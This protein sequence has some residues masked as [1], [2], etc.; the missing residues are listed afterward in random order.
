[1]LN[2]FRVRYA[3][4][5]IYTDVGRILVAINPFKSLSISGHEWI[6]DYRNGTK[7][8]PHIFKIA[9]S[10]MKGFA[11]NDKPQAV[12]V[13]GE[14]GAGKTESAK[15]VFKYL[16]D[17][18]G[19]NADATLNERILQSNPI[20]EAFGNAKTVHNNNSSRFGKFVQCKMTPGADI[21]GAEIF[22]YLLE[23]NRVCHSNKG[24]RNYHIFYQ[25]ARSPKGAEYYM[26]DKMWYLNQGDN[27]CPG[28]DDAQEFLDLCRAFSAMGITS[29]EQDMIFSIV[30]GVAHLGNVELVGVNDGEE[31]E[32]KNMKPVE[33]AAEF[34]GGC[35]AETLAATFTKKELRVGRD[36]T[37]KN[38]KPA[39]SLAAR[40]G[41]AMFMYDKLF[42]WLVQRLNS[43]LKETEEGKTINSSPN[44]IGV[45]DIAGF[46]NFP[47]N[48]L[49]QLFINLANENLQ[50][51]FNFQVFQ[52]HLADYAREG[53]T[54]S[55]FHYE[56][57]QIIMDLI[58]ND[59]NSILKTLDDVMKR[60]KATD[61]LFVNELDKVHKSHKHYI[62]AK[63]GGTPTFGIDHYAGD[64]TYDA[65]GWCEKNNV[66]TLPGAVACME[67]S[68]N[69]VVQDMLGVGNG[70]DNKKVKSVS[71]NY[72]SSLKD[73]IAKLNQAE[74]H[75][76]RCVK[77]NIEKRPGIFTVPKILPQLQNLG[78]MAAITIHQ[79]GYALRLPFEEFL[80]RYL[81]ILQN[82]DRRSIRKA[83]SDGDDPK[84]LVPDFM[85]KAEKVARALKMTW[86][87]G[88]EGQ[89]W[90]CGKSKAMMKSTV[91][92][93]LDKIKAVRLH[94]P[95][96]LMQKV[97][98]G[99]RARRD[100]K[101]LRRLMD[102]G[103]AFQKQH[104]P[105]HNPPAKSWWN[106][107]IQQTGNPNARE[108]L[109]KLK[110]KNQA[111]VDHFDKVAFKHVI[112]T[113]CHASLSQIDAEV[114]LVKQAHFIMDEN[115]LSVTDL[116]NL[117]SKAKAIFL[118][119]GI[120]DEIE[121]RFKMLKEQ[122][123]TANAL[124]KGLSAGMELATLGA[125]IEEAQSKYGDDKWIDMEDQD[126]FFN[127][128][129]EYNKQLEAAKA[130]AGVE[131]GDEDPEKAARVAELKA[132]IAAK[133]VVVDESQQR[134][135]GLAQ[136]LGEK[137]EDLEAM[138]EG[139][140]DEDTWANVNQAVEDLQNELQDE[141]DN[142]EAHKAE[143]EEME[144]EL[145]S[146]EGGGAVPDTLKSFRTAKVNK[147]DLLA[148]RD[149]GDPDRMQSR[150]KSRRSVHNIQQCSEEELEARLHNQTQLYD[151]TGI[152][153]SL[154]M[155]EEKRFDMETPV[156]EDAMDILEKLQDADFVYDRFMEA[157]KKW[158]RSPREDRLLKKM[159]NLCQVHKNL[160]K[161]DI[162]SNMTTYLLKGLQLI[163]ENDDG[164]A[165]VLEIMP[166]WMF[167][168]ETC[169]KLRPQWRAAGA[170]THRG[171]G[172]DDVHRS[173]TL[174]TLDKDERLALANFK[175]IQVFMKDR[176][177]SNIDRMALLD[178]V[179]QK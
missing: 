25:L 170:L 107:I 68:N 32:I 70:S 123:A 28:V 74:P 35:N 133:V 2:S 60:P 67:T 146:L 63:F 141:D 142:Y 132:L 79:R 1:M 156:Y 53:V 6:L 160:G 76:V 17:C 95:V 124:L 154:N 151:E 179:R 96:I 22:E 127:A 136:D 100:T 14:S 66:K 130:E 81:A 118:T 167:G 143:L 36:V 72:A 126:I 93:A 122:K 164:V 129:D 19:T 31:T 162:S 91:S 110:D 69:K 148:E 175:N 59:R 131:T 43:S 20:L 120:F 88:G 73:L 178:E 71:R 117:N 155:A 38:L 152:T 3:R 54:I 104:S 34:F 48:S 161:I 177:G 18:R 116:D 29:E 52:D 169:P 42:S 57:N 58:E 166:N 112:V 113:H 26:N 139:D 109:D 51:F 163:P 128:R 47:K 78:V 103:V 21:Y 13:A 27:K 9:R 49:E 62:K 82:R 84:Q 33:L 37:Y 44:W 144:K 158:V 87:P 7:N 171:I 80:F 159:T 46:E 114:A 94:D 99:Y 8:Q 41:L 105:G 85:M 39:D 176:L 23:T 4:N 45:L 168:W 55:D 16:T 140:V 10:A 92:D 150:M 24:E 165:A 98:R 108:D 106:V 149:D 61:Q 121:A 15:L 134:C 125:M 56:D 12:L 119:G 101:K 174:V 50:Q 89:T 77:P 97:F 64:V 115:V 102:E 138:R 135:I 86:P 75:F 90:A 5:D 153:E 147:D 157:Q 173:F 11:E 30:A 40:D 145:A 65:D 111:M 137:E 172:A 83:L